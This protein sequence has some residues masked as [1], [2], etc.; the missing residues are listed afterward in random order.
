MAARRLSCV[1]GASAGVLGVS[2]VCAG[3]ANFQLNLSLTARAISSGLADDGVTPIND[4]LT[5][6][7]GSTNGMVLASPGQTYVV[8]LR[9]NITDLT[10]NDNSGSLGL[11]T[12]VIYIAGSNSNGSASKFKLTNFLDSGSDINGNPAGV[13]VLNPDNSGP[14]LGDTGMNNVFR[15]GMLSG[16]GNSN[17][18]FS[19]SNGAT[20]VFLSGF[21]IQPLSL[22]IPTS[23]TSMRSWSS[24]TQPTPANENG[25]HSVWAIYDFLYTVGAGSNTITASVLQSP[26]GVGFSF[27]EQT[28][29]NRSDIGVPSALVSNGTISF[30]VP[31]P[32]SVAMLGLG[33]L[34]AVRRRRS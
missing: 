23:P 5:D 4:I 29:P 16:D 12:A 2:L 34:I 32:V 33:G 9:Y 15:E 26:P 18:G 20:G 19:P 8:E 28:G 24:G 3:Q 7:P 21:E 30:V 25:N 10:P 1:C 13:P 27:F 6:V 14:A 11:E 31:A 22:S 17:N